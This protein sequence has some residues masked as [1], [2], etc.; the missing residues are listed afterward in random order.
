MCKF[1]QLL[2]KNKQFGGICDSGL[3]VDIVK[4]FS[5]YKC[6]IFKYMVRACKDNK[7]NENY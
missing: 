2:N 7:N 5:F 6:L 1:K 4:L 3:K